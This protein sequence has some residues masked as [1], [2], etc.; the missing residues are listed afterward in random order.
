VGDRPHGKE[1]KKLMKT[2]RD[3]LQNPKKKEAPKIKGASIPISIA[4][5]REQIKKI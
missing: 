2:E 5:Y 3:H 1:V 4:K